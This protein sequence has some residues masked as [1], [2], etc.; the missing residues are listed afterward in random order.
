M[1]FTLTVEVT[2]R[3]AEHLRE[4]PS[5]GIFLQGVSLIGCNWVHPPGEARDG[6]THGRCDL[7]VLHATCAL[8]VVTEDDARRGK[9]GGRRAQPE[10]KRKGI[11]KCPVYVTS[12]GTREDE[13]DC[14]FHLQFAC[15]DPAEAT[16]W[17]MRAVRCALR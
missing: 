5:E 2:G 17:T 8:P 6:Q 1:G 15:D 12:A 7:P 9:G 14:V 13:R 3:D 11:F 16:R 10:P 4:G